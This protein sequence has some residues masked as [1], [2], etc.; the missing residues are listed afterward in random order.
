[1]GHFWHFSPNF[2]KTRF[3]TEK[4]GCQFLTPNI[5]KIRKIQLPYSRKMRMYVRADGWHWNHRTNPNP[6]RVCVSTNILFCIAITN[7]TNKKITNTTNKKEKHANNLKINIM[8]VHWEQTPYQY[9]CQVSS[10]K[11]LTPSMP[12]HFSY[13]SNHYPLLLP[14]LP[15]RNTLFLPHFS[16]EL[17]L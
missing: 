2:G 5:P 16:G 13:W 9:Q 15:S 3:F 12:G 8:F 10:V 6:I 4:S 14:H 7:K 11:R 17:S 1:M